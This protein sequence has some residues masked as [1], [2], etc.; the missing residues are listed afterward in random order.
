MSAAA[1]RSEAAELPGAAGQGAVL[2]RYFVLG[3]LPK[4]TGTAKNLR[5]NG[6]NGLWV[7][8]RYHCR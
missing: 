1:A 5:C 2:R 3:L 8:L 7:L 6:F 4:V